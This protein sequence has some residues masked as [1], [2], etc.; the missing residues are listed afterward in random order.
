VEI[1]QLLI[2]VLAVPALNWLFRNA[3]SERMGTI[4][5]SAILAHSGWHWASGRAADLMAYSFQWP[6]FNFAFL[7]ALMR[8][9][10]LL[11]IIGS[12]VWILFAVYKRFLRLNS[13]PNL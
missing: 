1:G 4:I 7:A 3:V 9:A 2:V 10:I 13:E 5:F 12:A 11:L 8:W 6:A